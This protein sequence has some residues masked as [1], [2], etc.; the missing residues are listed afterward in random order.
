MITAAEAAKFCRM[1]AF[2]VRSAPMGMVPLRIEGYPDLVDMTPEEMDMI[3]A[4]YEEIDAIYNR[5]LAESFSET[6]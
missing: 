6:K 2:A 1:Q 4:R 5:K 3:A